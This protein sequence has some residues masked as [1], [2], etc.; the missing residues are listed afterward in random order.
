[1]PIPSFC[2]VMVARSVLMQNYSNFVI[3]DGSA[4]FYDIKSFIQTTYVF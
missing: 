1:M 4:S 2:V 3:L